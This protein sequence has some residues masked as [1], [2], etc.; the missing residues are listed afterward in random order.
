MVYE[1]VKRKKAIESGSQIEEIKIL[2][3]KL[4]VVTN[5]F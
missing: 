2:V 3:K 5:Y 4:K 1:K